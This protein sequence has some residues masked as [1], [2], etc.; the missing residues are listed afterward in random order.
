MIF[1]FQARQLGNPNPLFAKVFGPLWN[2]RNAAL[3]EAAFELLALQPDD[4]VLDVGF[5]GGYLLS[6]MAAQVTDGFLAGVDISQALVA[7]GQKRFRALVAASKLDLQCARAEALPFPGGHFSKACSVNSIFYWENVP[8][9]LAEL[10][11]VLGAHGKLVLCQTSASGLAGKGFASH[12]N[13]YEAQD[14]EQ[15]LAVAGFEAIHVHHAADRYR[16]Y[17]CLSGTKL[18]PL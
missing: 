15:L 9:A 7:A 12:V 4:R 13:R 10:N 18:S 14:V 1:R 3:N 6:R 8:L 17:F 5:G 16:A 11:R 2:R